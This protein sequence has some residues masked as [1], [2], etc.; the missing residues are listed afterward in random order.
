MSGIQK[1][2]S[3]FCNPF[4]QDFFKTNIFSGAIVLFIPVHFFFHIDILFSAPL[5]SSMSCPSFLLSS[6]MVYRQ[7]VPFSSSFFLPFP[8]SLY[9]M[10]L[11][12]FFV[13]LHVFSVF[14]F[15]LFEYLFRKRFLFS[16]HKI[17]CNSENSSTRIH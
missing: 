11:S 5:T 2:P 1:K 3:R 14:S 4:M 15:F 9:M 7:S 8:L 17:M 13:H 10:V 16:I 12:V 6:Y